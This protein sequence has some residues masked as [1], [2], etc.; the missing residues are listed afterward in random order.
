[1]NI[2]NISI[3]FQIILGIISIGVLI[4][5][6]GILSSS[7]KNIKDRV[8]ALEKKQDNDFRDMHEKINEIYQLMFKNRL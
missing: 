3:I 2:Q 8:D 4:F 6:M 7:V 5:N 1:M